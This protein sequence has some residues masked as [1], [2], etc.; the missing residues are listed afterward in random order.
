MPS[1][2]PD[3]LLL[4]D[5]LRL[6]LPKGK[7]LSVAAYPPP[8]IH[9]PNLLVHWEKEYFMEVSRRV[10]QVVPMMYDTGIRSTTTYTDL[11]AK[12]TKQ[13]LQWSGKT[14]VLL[15]LPAYD[16]AWATYHDPTIENIV[17]SIKGINRGLKATE[18][19]PD[20]F[21]GVA[22]YSEWEMD[23]KKWGLL[24]DAILSI[25]QGPVKRKY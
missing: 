8:T 11:V 12:W 14:E 17:N 2:H 19:I 23:D 20:N 15:G 1:G 6:A 5:E 3:F 10:D 9:Q 4:L 21:Q 24:N 13:V 25:P 7:I 18:T 16:D 22:V